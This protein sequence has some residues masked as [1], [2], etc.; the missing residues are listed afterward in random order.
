M[1]QTDKPTTLLDI[2]KFTA[3]TQSFYLFE[4]QIFRNPP[5][6]CV[7]AVGKMSSSVHADNYRDLLQPKPNGQHIAHMDLYPVLLAGCPARHTVDDPQGFRAA[8]T[9]DVLEDFG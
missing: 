3:E 7:S 6:L 2:F 4:N 5:R 1:R 8:A 9:A